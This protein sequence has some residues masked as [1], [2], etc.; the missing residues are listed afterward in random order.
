MYLT[1]V[2]WGGGGNEKKAK[3]SQ[4][5]IYLLHYSTTTIV[6]P[7]SAG[8]PNGIRNDLLL[9]QI[10]LLHHIDIKAGGDMPGNMAV[11]GPHARVVGTVLK[12]QMSV[13]LQQLHIPPLRIFEIGN[14]A[15]PLGFGPVGQDEEIVPVEVYRVRGKAAVSKNNP[16]ALVLARVVHI[17]LRVEMVG[18]VSRV[19]EQKDR[20]V[21]VGAERG[22]AHRPEVIAGFVLAEGDIDCFSRF[23]ILHSGEGEKG[24]GFVEEVVSTARI[25]DRRWVRG[26]RL[27]CVGAFV[28]DGRQ[29]YP[30]IIGAQGAG[31]ADFRS[32]KNRGAGWQFRLHNDVG[33]LSNAK[34]DKLGGVGVDGDEI[35]GHDNHGVI[36]DGKSHYGFGGRIDEPEAMSSP[37]GETEFGDPSVGGASYI[38]LDCAIVVHLA[39]N[40]TVVWYGCKKIWVTLW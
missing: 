34:S 30:L 15:V 6:G 35:I 18:R 11:Q 3:S 25:I 31:A 7:I 13:R 36:V 8:L 38:R 32:H 5:R 28:E 29:G 1:Q 21:V 14:G 37:W 9:D 4:T 26:R 22:T 23:R 10:G 40:E 16:H 24:N 39:V 27:G 19:G 17:P 20:V 33:P 2:P 12:D